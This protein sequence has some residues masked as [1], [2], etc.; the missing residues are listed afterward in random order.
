M[1]KQVSI[2]RLRELGI[3]PRRELG[4]NFLIDDNVL[5]VAERLLPLRQEDVVL[6]VGPG[7][8]V[9]T[10][11]LAE[12]VSLVHG[13]ELDRR[14]E[15]ALAS[16]L[17]GVSNVRLLFADAMDVD[18]GALEPRPSAL[19]AN[20]PYNVATP[21]IMNALPVTS[22]FCVMVQREIA[23]RLFA[24][25]GSKAYGAVSVLVQL[26]TRRIGMRPVSRRVFTPVPNVD[27]ALVAFERTGDLA[28]SPE[29]GRLSEVVHGA[30]AHRRKRLA[31]SLSLAGLP[32]PPAEYAGLRAEQLEPRQFLE[33][34]G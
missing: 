4:Q 19:V 10:R 15:P 17:G 25:P 20:L 16:T 29:W 9:L 11:W 30:F 12:R 8:G 33:L 32:E 7:L 3:T 26:A 6:E 14:L 2:A 21:V 18:F 24:S 5:G 1:S 13:I 34:L 23:D 28:E 27:S 31:N 22:R